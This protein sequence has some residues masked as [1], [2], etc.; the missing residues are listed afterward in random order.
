MHREISPLRQAEDAVLVDT[1]SMTIDQVVET[2][3]ELINN[4]R[5]R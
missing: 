2:I 1:S 4:K 3:M 5:Q